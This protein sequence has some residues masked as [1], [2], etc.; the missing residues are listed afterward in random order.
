MQVQPGGSGRARMITT[1]VSQV[2]SEGFV[3]GWELVGVM[4]IRPM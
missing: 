2:D 4:D 1:L 3:D